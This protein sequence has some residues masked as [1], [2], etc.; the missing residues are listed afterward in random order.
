MKFSGDLLMTDP[1]Y[2]VAS[3]ADW[4][5][6]LS[7][8]YDRAA[9]HLLGICDFLSAEAGDDTVRCVIG[10]N[11]DRIGAFCTDSTLFCVCDLAQVLAYNP[12]FLTKNEK[13]PDTFCVILDFDGDVSVLYDENGAV[14]FIGKGKNA[15]RTAVEV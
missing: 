6:V 8:G 3:E 9:L 4:Q 5:L 1:A 13:Y 10:A 2:L 12:D 15:F 7:E 14:N 11:D